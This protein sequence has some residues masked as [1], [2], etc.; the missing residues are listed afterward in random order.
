MCLVLAYSLWSVSRQCCAWPTPPKKYGT[1]S[2]A[3]RRRHGC[4]QSTDDCNASRTRRARGTSL[5]SL[6]LHTMPGLDGGN[7]TEYLGMHNT[8]NGRKAGR[9]Y[10]WTIEDCRFG[11]AQQLAS[12]NGKLVSV[13]S[14]A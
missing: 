10:I 4:K 9:N 12:K 1:S 11:P 2:R 6:N 8:R 3:T 5:Y 13:Q 7:W 14:I